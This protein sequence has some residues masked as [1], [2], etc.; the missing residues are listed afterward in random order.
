MLFYP[1]CT[2]A[3]SNEPS[4]PLHTIHHV[5][6]QVNQVGGPAEKHDVIST[7]SPGNECSQSKEPQSLELLSV[8]TGKL[9][10][11]SGCSAVTLVT[12]VCAYN[13]ADG[14]ATGHFMINERWSFYND[15]FQPLVWRISVEA[16]LRFLWLSSLS[17]LCAH[18]FISFYL[19]TTLSYPPPTLRCRVFVGGGCL[20]GW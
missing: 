8:T 19:L 13:F 2:T 7:S 9:V 5:T 15:L 14:D 1:Q 12:K 3:P 20:Q 11:F 18:S 17:I 6:Y 4:L 10:I 16:A